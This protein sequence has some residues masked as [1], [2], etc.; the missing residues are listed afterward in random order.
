MKLTVVIP[1]C[2]ADYQRAL[3]NLIW[4]AE[5]G[6]LPWNDCVLIAANA[7]SAESLD[8]IT[9]KA[10]EVFGK[11]VAIRP[12][13]ALK[14]ESF[15]RG[16]NWMF[17]TAFKHIQST[18]S[19]NP[20]LWLEPDAVPTRSGWLLE[21]EEEYLNGMAQGYPILAHIIELKDA[22]FPAKIPSGVAIYPNNSYLLFK[23][24]QTNRNKPW[25]ITFAD[26][27]AKRAFHT[28]RIWNRLNRKFPPTFQLRISP[29]SPSF[30]VPLEEVKTAALVHP[31]KDGSLQAIFRKT[32]ALVRHTVTL[33]KPAILRPV[34][35]TLA[36]V[37]YLP[38]NR[39]KGVKS[40]KENLKQF[41]LRH[42]LIC[43]SDCDV[44]NGTFK[45]DN[46]ETCKGHENRLAV[47]NCLFLQG[48]NI[49]IRQ[50]VDF[51]LWMEADCRVKGDEWDGVLFDEFLAQ[52]NA[53]IC[54][55][56]VIRNLDET[57]KLNQDKAH[58]LATKFQDATKIGVVLQHGDQ[59]GFMLHTNG[60]IGIYSTALLAKIFPERENPLENA[61]K[62]KA[63]D[64][65]IG[66][67]LPKL[68]Y[69]PFTVFGLLTK[70]YSGWQNQVLE[71]RK[72]KWLITKHGFVAVHQIKEEWLPPS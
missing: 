38:P 61:H 22:K 10:K 23:S 25:D 49:A 4:I 37:T 7:I 29:G 1:F 13:F 51:M 33:T 15:P 20:W 36:T 2:T 62:L 48:L 39:L 55:S 8:A 72:R 67:R 54:G 65:D 58:A 40:Y 34:N 50:K 6:R 59:L 5:L 14:D 12:P 16:P 46:P 31:C 53:L 19:T 32:A 30:A 18:K 60:A 9:A 11:V 41:K 63:W 66:I 24:L 71:G 42:R 26:E 45:I 43:F 68:G 64:L 44:S 70:S 69:D 27:I 21:L 57:S 3:D 56:P 28:K 35:P 47:I 17:E 52:P